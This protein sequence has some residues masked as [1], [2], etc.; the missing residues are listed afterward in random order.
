MSFLPFVLSFLLILVLGSSLLFTSFRGSAIEKTIILT[1]NK[2]WL[3]LISKQ[4]KAEYKLTVNKDKKED[5][6]ASPHPAPKPQEERGEPNKTKKYKDER[7]QR[8]NLTSSK[9]N[10]WSL[11][12]NT[13]VD[14][15]IYE[16]AIKLVE[17]LYQDTDFY[18][19]ARDPGL[20]KRIIDAML[21][22]KKESLSELYPTDKGL[23]D[24]YY[25]MMKGTNTG[26]PRFEEYFRL[27]NSSDAPVRFAY[28]TTPVLKAVLG[29]DAANRILAAE[30]TAWEAN[31]RM[32]ALSKDTLAELLQKHPP[33]GFDNS[34]ITTIFSFNRAEKG[35]PQAHE[36][37]DSKITVISTESR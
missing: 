12:H 27:E 25:K 32:Q 8:L 17:I 2:N 9:F 21:G 28:A 1:E 23:S 35:I 3:E 24:I 10:L 4:A 22:Q 29:V 14:K 11:V 26:Y 33:R 31:H 6:P 18:K 5:K 36:D 19:A 7:N 13:T 16:S 34:H 37:Q 15:V 30:K 20:A